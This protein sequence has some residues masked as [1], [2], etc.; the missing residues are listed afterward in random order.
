MSK[1]KIQTG[2]KNKFL[3]A[4]SVPV[5]KISRDVKKLLIDMK[6]TLAAEK[7]LGLA[8]PQVGKNIRAVIIKIEEMYVPMINPE[9][10]RRSKEKEICEEGCLSLPKQYRYISRARE[11]TVSFLDIKGGEHILHLEKLSAR[12]TQHEIDHLD[13]VLISDY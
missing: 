7:G 2:P 1:L 6:Q 13:G 11:V 5:K 4:K 10:T 12:V 3:R 8:A 9:I